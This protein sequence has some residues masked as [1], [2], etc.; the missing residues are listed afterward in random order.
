MIDMLAC[1]E[2][3]G[4]QLEV[5]RR[6]SLALLALA[7]AV[8]VLMKL[9]GRRRF[10]HASPTIIEACHKGYAWSDIDQVYRAAGA[11]KLAAYRSR[12][13]RFDRLFALIYGVA[14]TV[15]GVWVYADGCR[16]LGERWFALSLIAIGLLAMI[17]DWL[18]GSALRRVTLAWQ[19]AHDGAETDLRPELALSASRRTVTKFWLFLVAFL[20]V[21]WFHVTAISPTWDL[22]TALACG[23]I[24]GVFLGK[25]NPDLREVEIPDAPPA[26]PKD[27]APAA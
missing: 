20:Q 19:K 10:G 14:A 26:P 15:T 16:G 6:V 5:L 4:F 8:Y 13:L 27:V 3:D 18:E 7:L 1:V 9:W 24:A 11:D 23:L 21:V 22:T 12:Q 2:T 25:P 17:F